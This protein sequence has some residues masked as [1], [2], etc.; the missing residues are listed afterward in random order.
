MVAKVSLGEHRPVMIKK[1]RT[2]K[3]APNFE[4]TKNPSKIGEEYDQNSK[5]T[6]FLGSPGI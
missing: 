3:L 1:L 4:A 6:M 5:C 2:D